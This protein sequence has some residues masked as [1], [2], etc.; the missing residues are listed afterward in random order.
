MCRVGGRDR[1][2]VHIGGERKHIIGDR[3]EGGRGGGGGG[4]IYTIDCYVTHSVQASA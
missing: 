2:R 3:M 1:G 4:E